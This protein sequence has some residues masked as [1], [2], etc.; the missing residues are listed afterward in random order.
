MDGDTC[1]RRR[2]DVTVEIRK[3]KREENLA[4]RRFVTESVGGGGTTVGG[5]FGLNPVGMA[6][7]SAGAAGGATTTLVRIEDLQK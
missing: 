5:G 3:Q 4:K 1:R 6:P 2:E 7:A